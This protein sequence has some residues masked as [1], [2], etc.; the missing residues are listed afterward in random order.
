M[1]RQSMRYTVLALVCFV[2][3]ANTGQAQS[4]FQSMN[5]QTS[6]FKI[7]ADTGLFQIDSAFIPLLP[8]NETAL[9]TT[10][11]GTLAFS[12]GVGTPC[13][14]S[15]DLG[16][17]FPDPFIP[18]PPPKIGAP[19]EIT[20]EYFSGSFQSSSDAYADLLAGLGEFQIG[21]G[22]S[23]PMELVVTPEPGSA[24]LFLC[25]L[26]LLMQRRI[27]RVSYW[28][29]EPSH[30]SRL[31]QAVHIAPKANCPFTPQ[32]ELVMNLWERI[33]EDN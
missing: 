6:Y 12:I 13:F 32:R 22:A 8:D 4:V 21:S 10:P 19:L 29:C 16:D 1:K 33:A 5:S 17:L 27:K 9:I 15:D 7:D 11:A 3:M 24:M 30:G 2:I 26:M 23:E 20:G 25:G 31:N 18:P 28:G 14:F